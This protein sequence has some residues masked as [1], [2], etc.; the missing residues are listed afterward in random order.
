MRKTVLCVV[1][2][3]PLVAGC[4]VGRTPQK[5]AASYFFN[6]FG[7]ITGGAMAVN[8]TNDNASWWP[9]STCHTGADGTQ[10]V[11]SFV[12]GA[13]TFGAIGLALAAAASVM[14]VVTI[15][16]PTVPEPA[17]SHPKATGTVTA[18]GLKPAS[19]T[20]R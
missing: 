17:T 20:L 9:S 13:K 2:M 12:P 18:P 3:L 19:V 14:M 16:V 7:M 4:L 15:V 8:L 10:C 11:S 1:A 5:K 6:G